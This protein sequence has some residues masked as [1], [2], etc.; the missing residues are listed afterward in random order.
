KPHQISEIAGYFQFDNIENVSRGVAGILSANPIECRRPAERQASFIATLLKRSIDR[1]DVIDD[2]A[3]RIK[4][5]L[6]M[7]D[8]LVDKWL[9][10]AVKLIGVGLE[11]AR[12]ALRDLKQYLNEKEFKAVVELIGCS[13]VDYR[14]AE[15]VA[16]N[17]RRQRVERHPLALN[18]E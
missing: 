8:P 16:E 3:A 9:N 2:A 5:D 13:W 15:R 11:R 17:A 12:P 6:G 7:W 10:F 1:E 4:L 14:S 18:A